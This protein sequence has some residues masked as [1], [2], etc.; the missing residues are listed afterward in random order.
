MVKATY[1]IYFKDTSYVQRSFFTNEIKN[2][3]FINQYNTSARESLKK[4]NSHTGKLNQYDYVFLLFI[5]Y[6]ECFLGTEKQII[7]RPII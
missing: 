2:G 3:E 1:I 6:F 5:T 7:V 4:S